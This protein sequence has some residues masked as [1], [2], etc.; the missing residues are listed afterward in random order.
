MI[1]DSHV[2]ITEDGKWFNTTYDASVDYLLKEM[3]R[4]GIDRSVLLPIAGTI[5]NEKIA[6]LC[7]KYPDRFIGFGTVDVNSLISQINIEEAINQIY[8]LGLCGIKIHP[9]LQKVIPNSEIIDRVIEQA[10]NKKLPVVFCGYQQC[11]CHQ[12]HLEQ[13]APYNYDYIAK[14]HPEA[15]IIIA[16]MGG[17]RALD[18]YF[19]S[20]SNPNVYLDTSYIFKALR[21]TS[22]YQDLIFILRNLDKKVIF[23]SDFPEINIPNYLNL[24]LE[25]MKQFDDCDLQAIC[26]QNL[27]SILPDRSA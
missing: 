12:I 18:A 17:H 24:I 22:V 20:K 16:H 5:S 25:E 9:R 23:G 1:I 19:V 2:H 11:L 13:L 4:S 8:S 10:V 6:D 14:R 15:K 26:S 21:E 7:A 3:D 27:L